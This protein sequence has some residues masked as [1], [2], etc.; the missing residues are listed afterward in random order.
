MQASGEK[1]KTTL[2]STNTR[3]R[4]NLV[5]GSTGRLTDFLIGPL[6]FA[7]WLTAPCASSQTTQNFAGPG[8]SW[9]HLFALPPGAQIHIA[10]DQMSKTCNLVSADNEKL[11][12][13]RDQSFFAAFTFARENV[14]SVELTRHGISSLRGVAGGWSA[15]QAIGCPRDFIHGRAIYRRPQAAIRFPRAGILDSPNNARVR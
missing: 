15:G 9:S 11:T 2:A 4:F 8:D 7:L 3:C 1:M 10:A 12:C 13:S 5:G 6:V 14:K